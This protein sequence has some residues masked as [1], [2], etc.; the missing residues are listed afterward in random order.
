MR[1][2]DLE[3]RGRALAERFLGRPLLHLG[4]SPMALT[5]GGL[6]LN[7]GAAALLA[8]GQGS[9]FL[10]TGVTYWVVVAETP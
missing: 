1:I 9:T 2:A 8:L 10:A 3:Q 5:L 7:G 6:L 4:L